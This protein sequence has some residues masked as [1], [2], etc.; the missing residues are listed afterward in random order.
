[1]SATIP[2]NKL[3]PSF[4]SLYRL[5]L[6]A[7]SVSVLHHRAAT[8]RVRTLWKPT[9]RDAAVVIHNL[10]SPTLETAEKERL[11]KWH[12]LWELCVDRTLSLLITSAQ[13]RGLPHRLTR[14][15]SLL[16]LGFQRYQ[17]SSHYGETQPWDPHQQ[18]YKP[19]RKARSSQLDAAHFDSQ[20]WGALEETVRMAEG[21]SRITLGRIE[22][23]LR[24]A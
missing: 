14:N 2:T 13:S 21:K 4:T 15:L 3:P 1:M 8:R 10:Q 19:A 23:R 7:S 11:E 20:S 12:R 6:R 16:H 22:F 18:V 5:F 17:E 9:F 24:R